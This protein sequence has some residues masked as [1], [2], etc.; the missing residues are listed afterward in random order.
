MLKMVWKAAPEKIIFHTVIFT[1]QAIL[2]FICNVYF[3]KK[4]IE[5]FEKEQGFAEFMKWILILLVLGS[6]RSLASIFYFQYINEQ[7]DLKIQKRMNSLL[8][9]KARKIDLECYENPEYYNKFNI[10]IDKIIFTLI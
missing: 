8:F 4:A 10:Y 9:E 5:I 7:L 3:I 2:D 6:I 1:M